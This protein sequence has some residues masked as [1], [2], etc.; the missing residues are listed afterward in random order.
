VLIII[1]SFNAGCA[2]A[3]TASPTTA[4]ANTTAPQPPTAAPGQPT[5][6]PAAAT[7]PAAPTAAP[8]AAPAAQPITLIIAT[9]ADLN[10]LDIHDASNLQTG[11]N[12]GM[13]VFDTLLQL[14][15]KGYEPRLA[16]SWEAA[17]D[18]WVFH[19]RQ[20]VTFQDG[21]PFNAAAV[22]FNADRLIGSKH[23]QASKWTSVKSAVVIDDYTV[24]FITNGAPSN[25]T[26]G[27]LVH[28]SGGAMQ[29]PTAVQAN[30][31][32]VGTGP[33]QFVDWKKGETLFLEKNPNY[34]GGVPKVDKVE[35]RV[36]PDAATRVLQLEAGEVDFAVRIPPADATRIKS[37]K[38]MVVYN[39]PSSGWRYIGLTTLY[40]PF[41]NKLVR[42]ALNYAVD[43][44]AIAKNILQD[45][46]LPLDSPYGSAMWG[47][48]DLPP[49]DYNPTK[50]KE[51]LTQAGYPNG[52][53]ADLIVSEGNN[54]AATAVGEAIQAYLKQVGV[55]VS[56]ETL[57]QAV[58][59]DRIFAVKDK[60]T[61]QMVDGQY[62]GA[63]PDSMRIMLAC[64]EVPPG[65]NN[66]F[67]CNPALDALFQQG[68]TETD[69]TK[70]AEIYKQ[71]QQMIW[72]DAPWIFLTELP[73][74]AAW[75][76]NIQGLTT[77]PANQNYYE[78]RNVTKTP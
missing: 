61:T 64:K 48:V 77:Y 17:A 51:L 41:Q 60:N 16:T 19:L 68:I 59:L 21:T 46:V 66:S 33:F 65:R 23:N 72:D 75:R 5:T 12:L 29:S 55:D 20:G 35:I 73:Q 70:R 27:Q 9:D 54:T 58:F 37:E 34:W 32:P 22:K 50:A 13:N 44:K 25:A 1:L 62:S 15:P 26:L 40:G 18:G 4:P 30:K 53:K 31:F 6:P 67:Y 52:F 78:L 43:A 57:D 14:G 38:G 39:P 2:P 74:I 7:Q 10:T 71:V 63:D 24:K 42:Q 47:H 56:V 49:Y 28:A 36:V 76:D 69:L 8:T 45:Y 11:E 3:A